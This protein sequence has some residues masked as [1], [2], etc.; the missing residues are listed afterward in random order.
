VVDWLRPKHFYISRHRKLYAAMVVCYGRDEPP[1]EVLV[2]H[3]LEKRQGASGK[4]KLEEVGGME[5]LQRLRQ[6]QHNTAYLRYYA[7]IV[8]SMAKFRALIDA[9]NKIAALGHSYGEQTPEQAIAA[10]ESLLLELGRDGS[11]SDFLTLDEVVNEYFAENAERDGQAGITTGYADLDDIAGG[12]QKADLTILAARPSTGKTALALNFAYH[13]VKEGRR[14]AFFSLEM[15]RQQ[16][17]LRLL[18]ID[19]GL[20]ARK[21]KQEDLL[22]D[23]EAGTLTV[24]LGHIGN[25][26]LLIQ[27]ASGL[28]ITAARSKVRRAHMEKPFDLIVTDYLQL[29]SVERQQGKQYNRVQ[30]VGEIARELKGM[31]RELNTPVLALSQL[32]RTVEGRAGHV[33]M[34]SDLRES[35]EIEQVADLVLFLHRPEMYDQEDRPGEADVIVAK[36]RNGKIGTATL[37][38]Q[39]QSQRFLPIAKHSQG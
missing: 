23:Y 22:D 17:L 32:S 35:G 9:G 29:H 7:D 25:L 33:P 27:D 26:P 12:W 10:A 3:E 15:S 4:T 16:L 2:A 28:N 14:V 30:E 18:A 24:A 34:L 38:F 36:N 6:S 20:D 37:V 1:T 11:E 13:A 8:L 5:E 21:V 39:K 19:T 31:A